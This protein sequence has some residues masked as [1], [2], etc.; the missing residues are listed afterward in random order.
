M[1]ACT[2]DGTPTGDAA[3]LCRACTADLEKVLAE[4]PALLDDADLTLSR[5]TAQGQRHG[6][7]SSEKALPYDVRA[8]DALGAARAALAGWV[9]VHHREPE[10]HDEWCERP[11]G[12]PCLC[13]YRCVHH[14]EDQKKTRQ[15]GGEPWPRDT[16]QDMARW[17]L[18]R[19][20]RIR[21]HEAADE[22]WRD[23]CGKPETITD[24]ATGKTTGT[25]YGLAERLRRATDRQ[26]ERW[27]AGPC[28]ADLASDQHGGYANQ[29]CAGELY[30]QPHAA[31]VTCPHCHTRYDM[32]ERRAWLLQHAEDHLLSATELARVLTRL[33]AP[34]TPATIRGWRHRGRIIPHAE[35]TRTGKAVPLYRVGDILD[36]LAIEAAK[37]GAA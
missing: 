15:V 31:Q 16:A 1:S 4:L 2:V 25:R 36:I 32:A 8:S 29:S 23:F 30:A 35:D 37:A 7:R 6:G 28:G 11:T 24:P 20:Q 22:L 9:Q 18:A 33:D 34:I 19:I 3:S 17:L 10:T 27:Y 26:T 5:Q 13:S 14:P 21:M 12:H